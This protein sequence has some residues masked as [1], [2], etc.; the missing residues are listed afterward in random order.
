M[1]TSVCCRHKK[2]R[3]WAG[4]RMRIAL[5]YSAIGFNGDLIDKQAVR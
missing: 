1:V 4:E 3:D 2:A 5:D